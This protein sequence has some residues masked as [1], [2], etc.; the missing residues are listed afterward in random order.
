MTHRTALLRS[1]PPVFK[2]AV[3]IAA[4]LAAAALLAGCSVVQVNGSWSTADDQLCLL[5]PGQRDPQLHA[6]L[7]KLLRA[8]HFEVTDLPAGTK[9]AACRQ[10][11]AY[12]WGVEQYYLP[13]VVKQYP[14]AFDFYLGG[15]K[16]ANASFDPTRNL[17]SPHVKFVRSSR[18]WARAL[19]RLF[20]GRPRIGD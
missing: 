11:L 16:I 19:D 17:I 1:R 5:G 6:L 12:R 7:K 14:V 20:P 15:E 18:Y 3:L 4:G 2:R 10:T 13:A 9:P 8:K